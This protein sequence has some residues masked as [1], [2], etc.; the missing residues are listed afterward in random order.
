M[1]RHGFTLIEV[2]AVLAIAALL[3]AL[4]L[5]AILK[6]REAARRIQSTNKLKQLILGVHGYAARKGSRLPG[7]ENLERPKGFDAS[8]FFAIYAE[9]I[10]ADPRVFLSPADPSLDYVDPSAGEADLRLLD[11]S[12]HPSSYAFN[13]IVFRPRRFPE[14]VPDGTSTTIGLAERYARCGSGPYPLTLFSLRHS[15]GGGSRRAS[16]ADRWYNDIVPT[17]SDVPPL[18]LPSAGTRTFQVAPPP[19]LAESRLPQTPHSGG[20][21]CAFMDGGVRP[22]VP[23]IARETFWGAVTPDGGE[24]LAADW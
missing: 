3:L 5:P 7:I 19:R 18:T 15:S 11:S 13:A 10:E 2:F 14:C 4:L 1:N 12:H 22:V 9:D 24:V 23:S 17:T 21:L 20:M 16:F 6:V 8:P